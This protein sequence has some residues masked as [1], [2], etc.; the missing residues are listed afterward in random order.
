MGESSA[1]RSARSSSQRYTAFVSYRHLPRDRHWAMRLMRRLEE[2]RPPRALLAEGFPDRVGAIFRDEDEIPASTDLSDQIKEA[3]AH[4]D[5][6][7]V[8]CTPDTPNSRWVRREIELFHELGKGDKILPV[9]VDGTPETSFP[10]EL[11]RRRRE[12][13]DSQGRAHEYWEEVEPIAADLRPRDDERRSATEERAMLRLAA[14]LLG[15]RYD[16]LARR[17]QRQRNSR[18]AAIAVVA[19]GILATVA[20]GATWYWDAM[21]RTKTAWYVAV[22][23]R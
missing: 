11:L 18:I 23:E 22:D 15:C 3:L 1:L 5:F 12:R 17:E 16:D 13:I 21:M 7:I 6:L 8:I 10:P 14:T 20:A 2:Y 4:S 19:F 9:L